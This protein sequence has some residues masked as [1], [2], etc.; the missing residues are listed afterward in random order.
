MQVNR[1][2]PYHWFIDDKEREVTCI[3]VYGLDV[4]NKNVCLRIDDFAPYAYVELPNNIEWTSSK[5]QLVGNKI[6]EILG[7]KKPLSKSLMYK[8]RLYGAH[9]DN[10]GNH[11]MFPFLRC[12]FSNIGDMKALSYKLKYP[13]TVVGCGQL[14]MKLHESD[15]NPILQMTCSRN[16][17]TAG[18]ID[19]NGKEYLGEDKLTICDREFQVKWKHLSPYES[20]ILPR[21]MIMGFD[22]EVNSQDTGKFPDA[23][24]PGDR[25]FQISC[26]MSR[27]GD[28]VNDYKS[29]LLTLGDPDQVITGNQVEIQRFKTEAAL[30]EGFAKFIRDKAPNVIVGYNILGFDIPYLIDRAKLN[31]CLSEFDRQGFHKYTH[32]NEKTIKWSS[33]AYKNQEFQF[34]DAEGR[35][36]VDLLPLVKRDYKMNNYKLKTVSEYFIGESKDPL[37]VQGIFKC[38]RLG[39]TKDEDGTYGPLARKAMAICGKYCVQDSVLVVRLMDKL[40][41]WVGLTEMAKTCQVSIFSLYTQGQQIKVYSQVYKFCMENNIVV[42]KDGYTTG[43][44]ERY[45]GAHVFPPVPGR[46]KGVVP[47]DFASLYPTTIIAYNIDYH[48]FVTDERIPDCKCHVMEWRDCIGCEHDPK[49]IR[50]KQLSD[51]ITKEQDKIKKLRE[52]RNSSKG[53]VKESLVVEIAELVAD[54]KTYTVER[55]EL[56]KSKPKVPMC[57]KRKY[58]FLKE[59]RGVLPTVIQNLLD[60]RKH[61]RKVDMKACTKELET[62]KDPLRIREL[63]SLLDVLDKRQLA[64][65]VSCNS[66][67]GAMGVRRGYL[68]FMPGAMCTTYMGRVNIEKV[69][70][71]ITTK[72]GGDLVYGDTDSNYI[73]FPHLKTAPEIWDHAIHVADEI[74]KMFPKPIELEFE[75]EIYD[76]FFILTKK[77]YMY[78]KCLRDGVVDEK[79]GKKGVLLAR[80]DNSKFIRD[81]YEGVI[82]RIADDESKNLVLEYVV[83]ELNQMCSG[84]KPLS[85]FV[86][87]KAV[88]DCGGLNIVPFTNEKG[89]KKARVGDYITPLLPAKDTLEYQ[90]ELDRKCAK[91]AKE[92]YLLCL[93]AQVQLAERMRRRGQRVDNGSRLEYV[94]ADPDR[95]TAKQ[96]EKVESVEYLAR[97]RDILKVDYLY[98][99]KLL[100]N[101]LDQV[102]SV[103]FK[104]IGDFVLDQYNFRYKIRGKVLQ[105]LR[106]MF[107]LRVKLE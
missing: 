80:R 56:N 14:R 81:V 104:D 42:E 50:S 90:E 33:S 70:D 100:A 77:R 43:E 3:R 78:R 86:V 24:K 95:H 37:S 64:Y 36:Y 103:A 106:E 2:F 55:A 67:Y 30:L 10:G 6:D 23:K 59:P 87:T 63:N 75:K 28:S 76:F 61:T 98:Y 89:Q 21:P 48:T 19:F 17:S 5:A 65:K 20:N 12:S 93:P 83:G 35:L 60:A 102:L 85:D 4:D 27:D 7:E 46:Q 38:Y 74:T 32:A 9:L 45:V 53:I 1:I 52:K 58:R 29:Y 13:L 11:R 97:H 73:R 72:F 91:D 18:W 25:V 99:I 101:P 96:Y 92:F 69:A 107:A 68:P 40:K 31:S 54:L 16:I 34:L 62:C 8:K 41:T 47:F 57:E 71:T 26:V 51:Y 22:I 82:S 39:I 94:I 105:E 49:V 84:C 44:A 66:M 88:G 15:A 79:I